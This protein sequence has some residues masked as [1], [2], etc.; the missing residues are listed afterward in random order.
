MVLLLIVRRS[1]AVGFLDIGGTTIKI[2]KNSC[3]DGELL[4]ENGFFTKRRPLSK[5]DHFVIFVQKTA[6]SFVP[7]S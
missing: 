4:D 7:G 5:F 2:M 6:E 3:S 1:L